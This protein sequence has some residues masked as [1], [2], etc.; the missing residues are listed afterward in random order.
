MAGF[1]LKEGAYEVR[2]ASD[3]ELWSAFAC[4]F[5][6]KSRNDSS[7]K[8]GFL[9]AIIDNLYNVDTDLRLSFDQLFSKFSEIYWNLI[10]KHGLRQKAV[11]DGIYCNDTNRKFF[12][13]IAL[14]ADIASAI[15]DRKLH[16]QFTVRSAA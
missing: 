3:D 4:V 15:C 7:Y 13:F 8:Y 5:S 16:V 2:N 10:L 6:S 12:I 11:L 9:K 14:R 1:D